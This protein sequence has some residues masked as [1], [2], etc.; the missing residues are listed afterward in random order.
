M[1]DKKN[2]TIQDRGWDDMRSVLDKELPVKKRKKRFGV[3][4]LFGFAT[5]II[6]AVSSLF[7]IQNSTPKNTISNA[8]SRSDLET[9]KLFNEQDVNENLTETTLSLEQHASTDKT[10]NDISNQNNSSIQSNNPKTLD[11]SYKESDELLNVVESLPSTKEAI[12]KKDI[13]IQEN[14]VSTIHLIDNSPRIVKHNKSNAEPTFSPAANIISP[15]IERQSAVESIQSQDVQLK[16]QHLE[17]RTIIIPFLKL[18]SIKNATIEKS[19]GETELTKPLIAMSSRSILRPYV[20]ASGNYQSNI[21]G[22]GYGAGLGVSYGSEE[23]QI[24]LEA[25]YH[26]SKFNRG[27][28]SYDFVPNADVTVVE[29]DGDLSEKFNFVENGVTYTQ[30]DLSLSNFSEITNSVRELKFEIGARK[31]LFSNFSLDVGIG[32][33]KLINASNKRLQLVYDTSTG[34]AFEEGNGV[35]NIGSRE[36]YNTGAYASYDIVPHIG[37][38]YAINSKLK[39]S[40]N[41]NLGLNNLIANTNL[42]RVNSTATNDK[43]YRRNLSAKVRY[44][45]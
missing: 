12:V 17:K 37:F 20:F 32:Y 10:N 4:F 7:T 31:R 45:F 44:A 23:F 25:G 14:T 11:L 33:S 41:Y 28:L 3:W 5:I 16:D 24:Y 30:L 38:E 43:I 18:P 39:F 35:F 34:S 22:I 15:L 6:L 36:L 1:S 21:K 40:F 13:I 26:K 8:I 29:D 27:T 9:S 19:T 42:D 2:R